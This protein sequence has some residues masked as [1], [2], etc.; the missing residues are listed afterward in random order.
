MTAAMKDRAHLEGL[1]LARY[2][3]FVG[4]VL[5][6]FKIAM[7]APSDETFLSFFVT[8]LE[9]RA[10]AT[11]VVLAGLGLGLSRRTEDRKNIISLAKRSLFLFILGLL[12]MLIFE[13]DIIHYYAIYFLVAAFFLTFSI[14]GLAL[15]ILLV[16][17]TFLL[18]IFLLDYD[19]GWNWDTFT[20]ADFWSF[21]GFFRNLFFNGWHPVFPWVGFVFFGLILS[22]LPLHQK[23][24]QHAL[25]AGG[26]TLLVVIEA[27]S[28]FLTPVLES[29]DPDLAFLATTKPVPPLTLY[30]V[31]GMG[32]SCFII[33]LCLRV[34]PL[35]K[36]IGLLPLLTP[37]GRQTLTLYFGHILIG[38]G[39]LEALQMLDEG[40]TIHQA[41]YAALL[42]CAGATGFSFFWAK[43]F[44]HGP[45]ES[46]MKFLGK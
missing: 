35:L 20:Y 4:M 8:S 14:R 39:I 40:Q 23:P 24:T 7:G 19:L 5:V 37:A 44:R 18:M 15:S 25:I 46:I 36:T 45:I 16:N 27:L 3:A 33:G 11:F 12:N 28:L 29:I 1:D 13:A 30:T 9:G 6:N 43:R 31:A 38:M 21:E 32:I 41:T 26:F 42:F 34:A 2:L 10:A 22:R 17:L